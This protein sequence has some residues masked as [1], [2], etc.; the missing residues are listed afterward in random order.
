V[1]PVRDLPP[2]RLARGLS[3]A[4]FV[5]VAHELMKSMI[6]GPIKAFY[7]KTTFR[8]GSPFKSYDTDVRSR[9]ENEFEACLLYLRDFMQT[10]DAEDVE[11]IQALRLHRNELAHDLIGRLPTLHPGDTA[12]CGSG[13]SALSTG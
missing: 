6:V 5:L 10:I 2:D 3:Y 12:T 9:H 7:A 1:D 13:R 11:A 8:P 4:G